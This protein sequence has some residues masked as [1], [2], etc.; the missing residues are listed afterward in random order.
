MRWL[1]GITDS[2]DMSL[3]KFWEMVKD[4]WEGKPGVLWS[5]G[6]PRPGHNS[7]HIFISRVALGLPLNLSGSQP[8]RWQNRNISSYIM[9]ST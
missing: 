8:P 6:L 7:N 3:S 4:P 2:M 1:D 5:L 9:Q